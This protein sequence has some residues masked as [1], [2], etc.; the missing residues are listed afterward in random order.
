MALYQLNPSIL[1]ADLA[2]LAEDVTKV[3]CSGAD[4]IH[5]DVMDNHYVPNLTF[6]P[7]ILSA[8]RKSG[9]TANIDVH[10]MV[11]PVDDL[12]DSFA[13]AG[14]S[15][16]VFHPEAS[17]HVHRSLSLIKSYGLQSGLALNPDTNIEICYDVSTLID[18]VLLMTVNPGFGGQSLISEVLNKIENMAK[19]IDDTNAEILLEVDGG[20]KISNIKSIAD[21][22]AKAFVIGSAIFSSNSYQK[23]IQAM[24]NELDLV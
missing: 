18:R 12:I 10:L 17:N 9:I 21:R 4:N 3:L 23:V 16:I 22:G 20:V 2:Y 24:R 19:W 1:S 14:A 5:F 13:K 15:S 11:E 8:L 7:M 6:G